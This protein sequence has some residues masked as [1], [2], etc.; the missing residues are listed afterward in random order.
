MIGYH[1]TRLHDEEIAD[2]LDRGLSPLSLEL[3]ERRIRRLQMAGTLTEVIAQHLIQHN[4]TDDRSRQQGGRSGMVWFLLTRSLLRSEDGIGISSLFRSWG[5][6]A[7]Y[8]C[9][10][11]K[12]EISSVLERIG[13][14]CIVEAILAVDAIVGS[15]IGEKLVCGFL[16]RR[17]VKIIDEHEAQG[18]VETPVA[19]QRILS[20][21]KRSHPDFE[22]L[23]ACSAWSL[24]LQ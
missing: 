21:I 20:V 22:Q 18:Y 19:G 11:D 24:P 12:P 16:H 5:G 8:A 7:L 4:W 17:R 14:P 15:V 13:T 23:T 3:V 10:E 1:C 2:I 6:E 9:H